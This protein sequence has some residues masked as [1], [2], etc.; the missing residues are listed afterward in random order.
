M[1]FKSPFQTLNIG[2]RERRVTLSTITSELKEFKWLPNIL[3]MQATSHKSLNTWPPGWNRQIITIIRRKSKISYKW[4]FHFLLLKV[5]VCIDTNLPHYP[6]TKVTKSSGDYRGNFSRHF[7]F[8]FTL[9]TKKGASWSVAYIILGIIKCLSSSNPS[10]LGCSTFNR[11]LWLL[12]CG[13]M[14]SCKLILTFQSAD[15]ILKPL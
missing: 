8:L 1:F 13:M 5:R 12:R 7:F 2:R 9:A 14:K 11:T 6:A 3:E 15:E 10:K 4:L